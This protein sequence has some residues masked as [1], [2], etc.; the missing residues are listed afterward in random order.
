M[1]GRGFFIYNLVFIVSVCV[2]VTKIADGNNFRGKIYLASWVQGVFLS[3][4]RED[5]MEQLTLLAGRC[6][7]GQVFIV[8]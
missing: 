4:F 8:W 6:G 5:K 7:R 2:A 3:N 1:A